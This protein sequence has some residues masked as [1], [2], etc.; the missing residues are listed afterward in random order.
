MQIHLEI[1]MTIDFTQRLDKD[2]WWHTTFGPWWGCVRVPGKTQDDGT[3][4]P[5]GCDNCYAAAFAKRVGQDVWGAK[6]DRR[7]FEDPYWARPLKWDQLAKQQGARGKIFCASMAD[8]FEQR[9]DLV[10]HRNR[11]FKLV[12]QTAQLDWMIP[13]KRPQN[14][15]RLLPPDFVYPHNL[16]LG[17][18]VCHQHDAEKRIPYLL[19]HRDA[20]VRF[21]SCEPLL[22]PVDIT[23]YLYPNKWGATVDWC[24]VGGESGAGSRPMN[25][26]WANHL[27]RQCKEANVPVF[28][29]Q[30]GN[31]VPE[32]IVEDDSRK[33]KNI[34]L[35]NSRGREIPMVRMSGKASI[36]EFRGELLKEFPRPQARR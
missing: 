5:S 28:F 2:K 3:T 35:F 12:H 1:K 13:T 11:L 31:W 15:K 36:N 9:L 17:T 30:Y 32:S 23:K 21:L 4:S 24:I 20:A 34:A 26:V 8:V 33:R 6:N 18:T 10:P 27:I 14:I 7:F 16:W 22:G 19:E 29:K 25:P